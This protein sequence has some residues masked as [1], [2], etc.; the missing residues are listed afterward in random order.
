MFQKVAGTK[1][2]YMIKGNLDQFPKLTC[3][4]KGLWRNSEN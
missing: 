3:Y 4:S 2:Y 1:F